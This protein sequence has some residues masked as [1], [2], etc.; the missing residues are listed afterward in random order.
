MD[1]AFENYLNLVA[2]FYYKATYQPTDILAN[3]D[4]NDLM[5]AGGEPNPLAAI[6]KPG[7]RG[8][9]AKPK[10][11]S[12]QPQENPQYSEVN[13]SEP[14]ISQMNDDKDQIDK[15]NA[16]VQL[17]QLAL[18]RVDIMDSLVS[19]LKV[20]SVFEKWS[21]KEIAIFEAALCKYGKEFSFIQFLVKSKTINQIIEFY[22]A[23]KGTSHYKIWKYY[24]NIE[25]RA[26]YNNWL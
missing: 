13:T 10:P 8:R 18:S 15:E 3:I 14:S 24:K 16:N 1:L 23:W 4:P 20:D 22:F 7:R 25:N 26:N 11:Q 5:P 2:Q 9:K 19:P 17:D 21:P 12:D 6:K